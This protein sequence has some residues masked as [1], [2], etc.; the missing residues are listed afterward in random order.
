MRSKLYELLKKRDMYKFIVMNLADIYF[1]ITFSLTIASIQ[2]QYI[3]N[4]TPIENIIYGAALITISIYMIYIA[5]IKNIIIK[6]FDKYNNINKSISDLLK[7]DQISAS[8]KRSC[9]SPIVLYIENKNRIKFKN[10]LKSGE[11]LS[12][13]K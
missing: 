2:I 3:I 1:M 8:V 12:W 4:S 6:S 13:I 10:K 9:K 7:N 11:Y 5:I